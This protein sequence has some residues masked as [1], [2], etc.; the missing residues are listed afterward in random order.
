MMVGFLCE[1][2]FCFVFLREYNDQFQLC[3]SARQ[4]QDDIK[5]PAYLQVSSRRKML[6]SLLSPIAVVY[7]QSDFGANS[8]FPQW[9]SIPTAVSK[10]S[11]GQQWPGRPKA[12]SLCFFLPVQAICKTQALGLS[13]WAQLRG[14]WGLTAGN[15]W[16]LSP[17]SHGF[18]GSKSVGSSFSVYQSAQSPFFFQLRRAFPCLAKTLASPWG[19][20]W[21]LAWTDDI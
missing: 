5:V 6:H 16:Q 4:P 1:V 21:R 2:F 18:E 14:A 19:K 10:D 9:G 15:H 17:Q 20:E 12:N 7:F 11:L 3:R 8:L 13:L